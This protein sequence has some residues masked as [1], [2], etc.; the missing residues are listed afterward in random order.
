MVIPYLGFL[1]LLGAERIVEL[2]LSRRNAQQA[3]HRGGIEAGAGHLGLMKALHGG[4]LVA[5]ALE[6]LLARRPFLPP[7]GGS[8]LALALL[9]QLIRYWAVIA[10]GERWNIRVIV[11][12]GQPA[13]TRGPYRWLR[14]PNY[15]AVALEGAAVP[16]IHTAWI[17]AAVFTGINACLLRVRVRC[18][19]AL[20][21][22]HCRYRER[23]GHRQRF[24]P[25][26]P[27]PPAMSR[28]VLRLRSPR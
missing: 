21:A 28:Q 19:E 15:L 6:V 12:P 3:L 9:A 1:A 11:M 7:L 4:F 16:L 5:C 20:L 2:L 24:W 13:I 25:S 27:V 26:R 10:L 23:L 18:E 8:M 17:T 14:H 22:Q